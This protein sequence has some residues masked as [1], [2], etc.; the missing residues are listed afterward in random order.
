MVNVIRG[1]EPKGHG[2]CETKET[3]KCEFSIFN[4]HRTEFESNAWAKRTHCWLTTDIRIEY[5]KRTL[6]EFPFSRNCVVSGKV[7]AR[8]R[9][10]QTKSRVSKRTKF[11]NLSLGTCAMCSPIIRFEH[12]QMH[13]V[14]GGRSVGRWWLDGNEASGSFHFRMQKNMENL[15]CA[16]F[17]SS[18]SLWILSAAMHEMEW[19]DRKTVMLMLTRRSPPCSKYFP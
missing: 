2:C 17:I 10:E 1:V 12:D 4:G 13:A 14:C 6:H 16:E 3:I 18:T 15:F 19:N 9:D 11:F 7:R 8:V 5:H